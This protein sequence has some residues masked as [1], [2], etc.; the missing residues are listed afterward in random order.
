MQSNYLIFAGEDY[1]PAGGSGDYICKCKDIQS[2]IGMAN[3]I[4]GTTI[5]PEN[6]NCHTYIWVH[7]FDLTKEE[8]ICKIGNRR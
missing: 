4:L 5:M 3:S 1:Y 6:D 7:I 2:A 8:I